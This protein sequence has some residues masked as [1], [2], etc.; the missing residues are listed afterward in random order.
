MAPF[1]LPE[2]RFS[3]LFQGAVKFPCGDDKRGLRDE[4]QAAGDEERRELPEQLPRVRHFMDD[5]DGE[6]DVDAP[7]PLRGEPEGVRLAPVRPDARHQ[8]LGS[9]FLPEE[10]EHLLLH[11]HG[12]HGPGAA[13]PPCELAGEEPRAAAEIEHPVAGLHVPLGEAVRAVKKT[14]ETRIEVRG[15]GR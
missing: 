8:A 11:V 10:P 5:E 15:A 6:G 12:D 7:V 3:R 14:A 13:G 9:Q 1:D 4:E 2:A